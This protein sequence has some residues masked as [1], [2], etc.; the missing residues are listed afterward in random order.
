MPTPTTPGICSSANWTAF[1]AARTSGGIS[2]WAV[3]Y[4]QTVQS[5]FVGGNFGLAELSYLHSCVRGRESEG[6]EHREIL[7]SISG[8]GSDLPATV[9]VYGANDSQPVTERRQIVEQT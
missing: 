6:D 2:I 9:D 1:F 8:N 3:H 7:G 5:I 4:P